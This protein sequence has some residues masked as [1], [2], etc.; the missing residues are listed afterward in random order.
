MIDINLIV[1]GEHVWYG[2]LGEEGWVLHES[3]Q[4]KRKGLY[5]MHGVVRPV[6]ILIL[7]DLKLIQ[8]MVEWYP[9]YKKK[10]IDSNTCWTEKV[11]RCINESVASSKVIF[12]ELLILCIWTLEGPII[13][14]IRPSKPF[15]STWNVW[16]RWGLHTDPSYWHFFFYRSPSHRHYKAQ[17]ALYW[18]TFRRK[19]IILCLFLKMYFDLCF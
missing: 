10:K 18:F 6:C 5:I 7:F 14:S 13:R 16:V 15:L 11:S 17:K 12:L 19:I 9:P 3:S 2:G 4:C 1:V 8:L